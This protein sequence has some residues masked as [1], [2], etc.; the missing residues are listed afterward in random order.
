MRSFNNKN[1]KVKEREREREREASEAKPSLLCREVMRNEP[2][3][4]GR[5]LA[6]RV[7]GFLTSE[8]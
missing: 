4:S 5:F 1:K 7:K 6:K 8:E 2:G 3:A